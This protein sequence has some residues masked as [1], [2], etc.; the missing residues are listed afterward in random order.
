MR[1]RPVDTNSE[2]CE[3]GL[4]SRKRGDDKPVGVTSS[5]QIPSGLVKF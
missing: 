4:R 5:S 1:S 2:T 3:Y